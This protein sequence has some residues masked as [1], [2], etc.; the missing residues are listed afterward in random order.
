MAII[1]RNGVTPDPLAAGAVAP[2]AF[3]LISALALFCY[4][5]SVAFAL[6][7]RSRR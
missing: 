3:G 6:T 5:V 7:A 2:M 1:W 4:G